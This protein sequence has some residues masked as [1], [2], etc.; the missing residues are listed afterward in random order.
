MNNNLTELLKQEVAELEAQIDRSRARIVLISQLLYGED[1]PVEAPPE[2][3]KKPAVKPAKKIIRTY[4]K[5]LSPDGKMSMMSAIKEILSAGKGNMTVVDVSEYALKYVN[6]GKVK[7]PAKPIKD[8][9]A[10]LLYNLA[11]QGDA[12]NVERGVYK[13]TGPKISPKKKRDNEDHSDDN[14]GVLGDTLI[15]FLANHPNKI[16]TA[17]DLKSHMV[18]SEN[19]LEISRNLSGS[20]IDAIRHLLNEFV[21]DG[22][23]DYDEQA[24]T[25]SINKKYA[26]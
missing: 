8:Y 18:N 12:E 15:D 10:G 1:E 17:D 5:K 6:S 22:K 14:G 9:V 20:L 21:N 11:K 4:E 13:W 16:Y 24:E 2:T 26:A 3:A 19:Y 23:V 25:F 7:K